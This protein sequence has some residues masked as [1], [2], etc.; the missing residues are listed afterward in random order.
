M[1]IS[2]K[3]R[4]L[5]PIKNVVNLSLKF[6]QKCSVIDIVIVMEKQP[7]ISIIIPVYNVQ[8]YLSKCLESIL[9]NQKLKDIEV[10]C[11]NDSSTDNSD[12]ILEKYAEKDKRVIL[13]RQKNS[14][15]G[16]ARNSALKYARGEYVLYLDPDDWI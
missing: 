3:F 4:I 11:I 2:F 5:S 14:G 8:K 1:K 6:C 9:S 16:A 13:L 15:A 7:K 10:I 12:K